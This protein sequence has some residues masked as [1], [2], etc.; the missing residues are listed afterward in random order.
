MRSNP[1]KHIVLAYVQNFLNRKLGYIML[2]VNNVFS[3]SK[4]SDP[5]TL[6][7]V[8]PWCMLVV[9]DITQELV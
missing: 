8:F 7:T 2:N 5:L 1:V 4:T 9:V 6:E 3:Y